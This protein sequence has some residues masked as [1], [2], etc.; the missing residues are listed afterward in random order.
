MKVNLEEG[1]GEVTDRKKRLQWDA[2]TRMLSCV[3]QK[4]ATEFFTVLMTKP[5]SHREDQW[6]H[7]GSKYFAAGKV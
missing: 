3:T 5:I 2:E 7:R 4:E 1:V 6:E